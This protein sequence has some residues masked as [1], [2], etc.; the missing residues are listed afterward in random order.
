MF[1]RWNLAVLFGVQ[2]R[3]FHVISMEDRVAALTTQ[4]QETDRVPELARR[5]RL[6]RPEVPR[7]EDA[8]Q[9]LLAC[10][11]KQAIESHLEI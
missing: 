6:Q 4:S 7:P 1:S 5:P 2:G 3:G 11:R 8:V 10:G 9:A